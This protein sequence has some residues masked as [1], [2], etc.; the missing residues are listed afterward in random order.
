MRDIILIEKD[1]DQDY[2]MKSIENNKKIQKYLE[3]NETK[4]IIF[5]RNKMINFVI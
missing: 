4:K 2:V 5:V 3:N 1:K